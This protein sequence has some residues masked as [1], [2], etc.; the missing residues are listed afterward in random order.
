MENI[1]DVAF[2]G[3]NVVSAED[4]FLDVSA[5]MRVTRERYG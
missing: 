5:L 1:A 3:E 2:P 4:R